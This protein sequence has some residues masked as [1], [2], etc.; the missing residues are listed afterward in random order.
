MLSSATD[1]V[2]VWSAVFGCATAVKVVVEPTNTDTLVALNTTDAG[3]GR[4]IVTSISSL[5]DGLLLAV[6]FTFTVP[7]ATGVNTPVL[8]SIVAIAV[9]ST[10][11]VTV[12][13]SASSLTVAVYWGVSSNV[14]LLSP[15]TSNE[16][17]IIASLTLTVLESCISLP[18]LAVAVIVIS[19]PLLASLFTVIVPVSL[20]YVALP[21]TLIVYSL[22]VAFSG[23]TVTV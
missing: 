11:Q 20:L 5:I 3:S 15:V 4:V 14:M 2:T 1:H 12:L 10:D 21:S 23:R 17:A 22:L 6:A 9:L 13:S 18:S 7:V 8:A 16:V 19:S